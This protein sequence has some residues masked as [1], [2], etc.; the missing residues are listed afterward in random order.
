MGKNCNRSTNIMKGADRLLMG[1][2]M[3][4]L[5]GAPLSEPIRAKLIEVIEEC[6][7]AL[8]PTVMPEWIRI[9]YIDDIATELEEIAELR[10]F[11]DAINT[12]EEVKTFTSC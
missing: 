5:E 12:P 6:Q 1:L 7:K 4:H 10:R 9:T 8:L 2:K 11:V 3:P